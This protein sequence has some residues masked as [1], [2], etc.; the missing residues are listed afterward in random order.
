MVEREESDQQTKMGIGAI[1]QSLV[2]ISPEWGR[3][4]LRLRRCTRVPTR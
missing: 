3:N 1:R 4:A 2:H